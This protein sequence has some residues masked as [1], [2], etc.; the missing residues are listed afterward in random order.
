MRR[1]RILVAD[2]HAVVLEGLVALTERTC[3]C[4]YQKDNP[5]VITRRRA[6]ARAFDLEPKMPA[7]SGTELG[8]TR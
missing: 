3:R 4:R 6:S 8:D 7:R 2:D 1:I 5:E